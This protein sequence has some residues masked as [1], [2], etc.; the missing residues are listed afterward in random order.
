MQAVNKNELLK[1]VGENLRNIRKEKQVEIKE[2]VK[3]LNIT[4]QAYGNIENGKADI[5]ISRLAD[6]ANLF[7]VDFNQILNTKGDSISYN[8]SSNSGGYHVNNGTINITQEKVLEDM[9]DEIALLKTQIESIL[10]KKK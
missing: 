2:V 3:L 4:P 1:K 6:I 8:S 9:H 10:Q 5:S 7:N